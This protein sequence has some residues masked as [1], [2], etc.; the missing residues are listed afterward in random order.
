[1]KPIPNYPG[2]YITVDGQVFSTRAHKGHSSCWLKQRKLNRGHFYVCLNHSWNRQLVH[3]LVLETYVGPCP[4]GMECCHND[5]NPENN[6]LE[7]L[8]WDTRSNNHKDKVRHGRWDN[9]TKCGE[10]HGGAKL[11]RDRVIEI[12]RLYEVEGF[13][14][15]KIAKMFEIGK[16]TVAHI[17]NKDNW[18]H[19]WSSQEIF[20]GI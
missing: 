7:N 10:E 20:G 15:R 17:L 11:T 19:L 18:K 12:V 8:R 3:R 4:E 13:S 2:Y 14:Q 1:M 5:G 6:K 9:P 16:T